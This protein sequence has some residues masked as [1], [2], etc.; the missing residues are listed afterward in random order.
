MWGEAGGLVGGDGVTLVEG[1]GVTVV[2]G[3]VRGGVGES[4]QRPS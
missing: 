3:V 1:D 2:E 4:P